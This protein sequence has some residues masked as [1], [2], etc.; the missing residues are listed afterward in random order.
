MYAKRLNGRDVLFFRNAPPLTA[1]DVNVGKRPTEPYPRAE[2]HQCS[3]YYFWWAFLRENTAYME[4]CANEGVGPMAAL[5]DDFGYVRGDD[6][7]QNFMNWW[8]RTRHLFSEP[9]EQKIEVFDQPPIDYDG[10]NRILLSLPISGDIDKTFTE[11]RRKL[12]PLYRDA[13]QRLRDAAR[14]GGRS[15]HGEQDISL[16][17]YPVVAKPVLTALYGYLRVW[18]ELKLDPEASPSVIAERAGILKNISGRD[19]EPNRV[20]Q[21]VQDYEKKAA[22]LIANVGLG[23]FPDF[24]ANP[25]ARDAR[26]NPF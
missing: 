8:K 20:R 24:T 1:L 3:V 16:A 23:R 21:R 10:R 7:R 17:T 12:S 14:S 13:R 26:G 9:P 25:D 4:C 15:N 2:Q 6:S 22:T 5:Y 19:E 11:L 18:Q